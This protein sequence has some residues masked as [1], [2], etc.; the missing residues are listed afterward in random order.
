MKTRIDNIKNGIVE[1]EIKN[2][3]KIEGIEITKFCNRVSDGS[4]VVI[5]NKQR[6][7]SPLVVG[8]GT[9]IKVNANIGTST[10]Q[11]DMNL[12]L[13]KLKISVENGADAVM[14]LS[15]GG[16]IREIRKK[17]IED[18]PVAIG[19][20]PI[21]QAIA[22]ITQKGMPGYKLKAKNFLDVVEK[23]CQEG[24]DF[25]TIHCG[26]NKTSAETF[27]NSKRL[28]GV[29]SRGGALTLEWMRRNNMENPYY[30][31]FDELLEILREYDV[32]ISLGDGFRPGSLHD[33]TDGSQI[34][35]LK[36]LG[37]LVER[38]RDANVGAIVEG[39]GHVPLHQ[40]ETNIK[41]Q[42]A[43]CHNAPFY[44]L[45]PLVTDVSP[46][47]DHISG[48][49]GGAI[50]AMSGA[51]FLCYLTPAEHLRLPSL[52]DVKE[53]VIASKIAAHA[54]D[55]ANGRSMDWDNKISKAKADLEWDEIIDLCIDS[56]KARKYRESL[57]PQE[58]GL[59]SMCG[60]FC[61]VKRSK[62]LKENYL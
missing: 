36:I 40:I 54:A 7:I 20:V 11:S 24:V 55:I 28:T 8:S 62:E 50:A 17:I 25:V 13:E 56:D 32:C 5:K 2:A 29:V 61:A 51:D 12:E 35:E 34:E 1:D 39:P 18:S 59:C 47:H 31:Y 42:K 14:D 15:T 22:D 3:A 6:K 38:S 43:L 26:I 16:P 21:Y 53:G 19:T 49:I 30:E 52:E 41:L 23:Q 57:P 44:V 60:E 37:E 33:A 9:K 48:A 10:A 45:G 58:S 27:Y 4:I 46:G